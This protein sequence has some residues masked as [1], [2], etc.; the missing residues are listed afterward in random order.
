MP[1]LVFILLI[2]ALPLATFGFIRVCD[3]LAPRE[4]RSVK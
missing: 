3:L 2:L 4:Q 1:D